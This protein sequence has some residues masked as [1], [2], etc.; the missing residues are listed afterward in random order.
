MSVDADV[1]VVINRKTG[2]VAASAAGLCFWT[3]INEELS[4]G[5]LKVLAKRMPGQR[6]E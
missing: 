2:S 1:L 6:S 3:T 5:Q 4:R